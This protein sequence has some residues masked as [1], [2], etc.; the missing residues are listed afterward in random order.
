MRARMTTGLVQPGKMDELVDR[1]Q[2]SVYPFYKQQQGFKGAL[3]LTD[4]SVPKS[5]SITLWD[6]QD[7]LTAGETASQELRAG[8][9][10][11]LKERMT[12]YFEVSVQV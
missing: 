10:E 7:D 12:E 6:T 4:P 5:I 8:L 1:L 2:A 9:L 3:L 11:L